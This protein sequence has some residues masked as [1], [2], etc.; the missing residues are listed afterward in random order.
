[1]T[2]EYLIITLG[3][4]HS[5]QLKFRIRPTALA[6]LW[7]DRM[8]QRYLYPL[9]H[10][11]RFYGFD[12][13][14]KEKSR[15]VSMIQRCIDIINNHEHIIEREFAYTQDYLNYL[16]NI[17]EK[18]HG[19]LDQQTSDYWSRAPAKVRIA[20]AELNLAVHRCE[21][22]LGSPVA[23]LV[24]TWFGLPKTHCLSKELQ[25]EYGETIIKF[26]TVY[27]NY[28]EI[29]KTLD[30]LAYDN[31][32][33][34]SDEAFRP[35]SHYSADFNVAFHDRDPTLR[36]SQIQNYIEQHS[37]FFLAKGITSV[38]NTQAQ[39]LY[40]PVAD[41]EYLGHRS[42]LIQQISSQQFVR[43]VKLQ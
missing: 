6:E 13:L 9:D 43:E 29:G 28:C 30:D 15:A 41:L 18:Y 11:D 26:G 2:S 38:Y 10:P 17:F 39:P 37:D 4:D 8:Q 14:A 23:R 32:A 35:F 22:V 20:L 19:L 5:T 40:F 3:N 27:L 33:Y 21:D 1:M 31:D 16:H 36:Y 7:L 12:D 24:C 34:I 42:D 25:R